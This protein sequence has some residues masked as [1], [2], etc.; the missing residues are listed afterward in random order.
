VAY[1]VVSLPDQFVL[2]ETADLN[3]IIVAVGNDPLQT[4]GG[5]QTGTLS[6]FYFALGDRQVCTHWFLSHQSTQ[7]G[8]PDAWKTSDRAK[9]A[10]SQVAI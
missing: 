1:D 4:R 6:H 3:K 8:H 5:D 9:E 10:R 2:S 7:P